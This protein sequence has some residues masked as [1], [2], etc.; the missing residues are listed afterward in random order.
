MSICK[1]IKHL[2]KLIA[3]PV[4][5]HSVVAKHVLEIIQN[6]QEN[7]MTKSKLECLQLVLVPL[8]EN[9]GFPLSDSLMAG[10][11]DC[12]ICAAIKAIADA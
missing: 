6:I 8:C 10:E 11:A 7:G 9:T 1:A 12:E 3:D 5:P 2:K 4:D